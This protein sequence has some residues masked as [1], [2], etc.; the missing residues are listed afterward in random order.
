MKPHQ[1]DTFMKNLSLILILSFF[2]MIQIEAQCSKSSRAGVHVVQP[3]ENLYRISKMYNVSMQDICIW[4]NITINQ[5]LPVCKE[6]IVHAKT[7]K[8]TPSTP[9]VSVP[10]IN[11]EVQDIFAEKSGGDYETDRSHRHVVQH[12][13]TIKF[14]AEKYGYT[15]TRFRTMNGLK[16]GE[17]LLSGSTLVTSNCYCKID[18]TPVIPPN[19]P[20]TST[21]TTTTHT[22]TNPHTTT[23]T[24]P[25]SISSDIL[26][27]KSEDSQSFQPATLAP[28]MSTKEYEMIKEINLLRQAPMSYALIIDQYKKKQNAKG[29]HVYDQTIDELIQQLLSTPT[30]SALHPAECM[31]SAAK[32]HGD[33]IK[34]MGNANHIGTD[35]SWPW[36]RVTRACLNF[37][38]GNENL[39]GGPETVREAV[40]LLLID[41][42]IPGRG[43]RN[44]LL[45]PH[46]THVV[47][48]H[49]G[50]VGSMPNV[51]V[52]KFGKL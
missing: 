35:G 4:N 36:D 39:V 49:V 17:E 15:E 2:G 11:P 50:T 52:Q 12:G 46:W 5:I 47:C 43:H 19:T 6:L 51:W 44:N 14:I 34:R 23:T 42:G 16:P 25:G 32:S 33:D 28:Y 41:H 10:S 7:S 40:I 37:Q 9:T 13:E 8:P 21:H 26:T 48:H 29:W 18:P 31:Y 1:I 38:D 27:S 24:Q 3:K 20:T 45:N 22:N 30:L